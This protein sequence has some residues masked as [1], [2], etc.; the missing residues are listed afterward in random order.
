MSSLIYHARL[1][2]CTG[3][4][5]C[6]PHFDLPQAHNLLPVMMCILCVNG[7]YL[8]TEKRGSVGAA[9]AYMQQLVPAIQSL[10]LTA[11]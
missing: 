6:T 11:L 10:N 9:C 4:R 5:Y 7:I 2:P 3:V 8:R 1:I